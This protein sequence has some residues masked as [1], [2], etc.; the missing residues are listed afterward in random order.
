M[1]AK[2]VS[3]S[4]IHII[5]SSGNFVVPIGETVEITEEEFKML[6]SFFKLERVEPEKKPEPKKDDSA[7]PAVAEHADPKP[8]SKNKA[9]K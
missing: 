4:K 6:G 9:K 1:I 3:K 8:K 2:N 7:E 5:V